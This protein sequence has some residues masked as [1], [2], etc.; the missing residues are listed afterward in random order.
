MTPKICSKC[1]KIKD[2]IKDFYMCSGSPRSECKRCTSTRNVAYARVKKTYLNKDQ[3]TEE[4]KAYM[5]DYYQKHPE[6]YAAYRSNF[7][8]NHP[9]YYKNY[10]RDQKEKK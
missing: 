3:T 9:D 2:A 10:F 6:K 7:K 8:K 1:H 4:R 5:R